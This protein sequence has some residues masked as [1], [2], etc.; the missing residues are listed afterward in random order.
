MLG[1]HE[2]LVSCG[3]LSMDGV[4]IVAGSYYRTVRVWQKEKVE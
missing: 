3:C 1:R 2:S 4:Q